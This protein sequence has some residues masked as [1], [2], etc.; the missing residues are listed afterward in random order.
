M[1]LSIPSVVKRMPPTRNKSPT[2]WIEAF[3]IKVKYLKRIAYTRDIKKPIAMTMQRGFMG[4]V[5]PKR[6]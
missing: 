4:A 2:T 6:S 3:F 5:I 1:G